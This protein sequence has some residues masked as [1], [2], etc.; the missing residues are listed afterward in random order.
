[1]PATS[2]LHTLSKPHHTRPLMLMIKLCVYECMCTP[3]GECIYTLVTKTPVLCI[4]LVYDRCST[5]LFD[6]CHT[7]HNLYKHTSTCTCITTVQQRLSHKTILDH[8]SLESQ[9]WTFILFD[10]KQ[11]TLRRT[12]TTVQ[13][14]RTS[15]AELAGSTPQTVAQPP[16]LILI[17]PV[18]SFYCAP[19]FRLPMWQNHQYPRN[20]NVAAVAVLENKHRSSALMWPV[21]PSSWSTQLS[22]QF[23]LSLAIFSREFEQNL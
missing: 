13:L 18:E 8:L 7:H 9:A 12:M 22:H 6:A 5:H 14:N 2:A 1:M 4:H 15:N 3:C 10:G 11:N 19:S 17:Q 23:F 21:D 16:H 20:L